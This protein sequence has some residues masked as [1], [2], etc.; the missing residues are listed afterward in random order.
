M[1]KATVGFV[2]ALFLIAPATSADPVGPVYVGQAAEH[3]DY[4]SPVLTAHSGPGG[5]TTC[6]SVAGAAVLAHHDSVA[7]PDVEGN[8][9]TLFAG[10]QFHAMTECL[11]AGSFFSDAECQT[12]DGYLL[13]ATST[14]ASDFELKFHATSGHVWFDQYVDVGEHDHIEGFLSQA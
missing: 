9:A 12:V 7:T 8:S 6:D 11:G 10:W 13:C 4:P 1:F 14:A 2:A 3:D 5:A